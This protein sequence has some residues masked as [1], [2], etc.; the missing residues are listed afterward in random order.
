MSTRS[1]KAMILLLLLGGCGTQKSL[2]DYA[3]L[4]VPEGYVLAGKYQQIEVDRF[5]DVYLV[6][7]D[8]EIVKL[9]GETQEILFRFSIRS[10][11]SIHAV[12]VS[13]PQK[14]FVYYADYSTIVFLD[15]TLSEIKRLDLEEMEL[16]DIQGATLARDNFIWLLDA[17]NVR[18]LKIDENGKILLSSNELDPHLRPFVDDIPLMQNKGQAIYLSNGEGITL[19][20]EF[21]AYHKQYDIA[22][23]VF[24]LDKDFI[25]YV[26]ELALYSYGIK[27]L[28]LN[29]TRNKLMRFEKPV[30]DFVKGQK[31]VHWIDAIGYRK[32]SL[33]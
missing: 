14:I 23:P 5:E 19:Y 2:V 29:K 32:A 13:N 30:L 17:S 3:S 10:L 8:N 21:G 33:Y 7:E 27:L 4:P 6:T 28:T 25:Y 11:G 16:W 20:D 31:D 26:D 22:S 24:Q 12:D 1:W 15:N 9:D 18:L